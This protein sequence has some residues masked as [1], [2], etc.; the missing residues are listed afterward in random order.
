M[1]VVAYMLV[2]FTGCE[3]ST[4]SQPREMYKASPHF[5]SFR[6][7]P[8]ITEDE[9]KAI[10]A[11]QKECDSFVYGMPESTE[12]FIVENKEIKGFSALFCGWL[13][14]LFGIPFKPAQYEWLDLLKG[15]DSGKVDFTGEMMATEVRHKKYFMTDAIAERLVRCYYLTSISLS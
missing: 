14:E 8:G 13:S 1:L 12:A 6:D 4:K 15:L 2:M 11:L 9:I 7:I 5:A 3:K 10:E